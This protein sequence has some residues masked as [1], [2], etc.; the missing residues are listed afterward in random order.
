MPGDA[1]RDLAMLDGLRTRDGVYCLAV[2]RIVTGVT[3]E[4]SVGVLRS[5]VCSPF[6]SSC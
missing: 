1:K 2:R 5:M 4:S 6:S 3:I